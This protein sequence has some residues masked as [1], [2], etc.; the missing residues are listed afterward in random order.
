M[1]RDA[2]D[3][4]LNDAESRRSGWG[5]DP[6]Y[7]RLVGSA[8]MAYADILLKVKPLEKELA[9]LE[10]E[11]QGTRDRLETMTKTISDLEGSIATLK[12]EY[13]ELISATQQIKSDLAAGKERVARATDLLKGLSGE[14]ERWERSS[15]G[16]RTQ[17][18]N[19]SAT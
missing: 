15:E 12:A 14:R 2:L 8:Q 9:G 6:R 17:M 3:A 5:E 7:W 19:M 11:A 18:T 10:S 1:D 4:I 16:F 13:A